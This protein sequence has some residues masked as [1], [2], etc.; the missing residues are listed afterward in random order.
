MS[1][2]NSALSLFLP[3]EVRARSHRLLERAEAGKSAH[4]EVDLAR[5]GDALALVLETA[6]ET[7]PDFLIP[8]YGI[9]RD[10]EAG[11]LDRW[12]RWQAPAALRQQM[13]CWPPLR[14]LPCSPHS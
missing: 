7:Y 12:G 9:W 10:L 11:G 3:Q 2:S 4:L 1:K 13:R 14:I 8:P 6:R 5:L